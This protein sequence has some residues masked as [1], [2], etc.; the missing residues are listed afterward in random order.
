MIDE[1][2][3]WFNDN[4]M[5]IQWKFN[6][7]FQIFP[8]NFSPPEAKNILKLRI[9]NSSFMA[10]FSQRFQL[11]DSTFIHVNFTLNYSQYRRLP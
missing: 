7:S 5:E 11:V 10:L 9:P 3:E 1:I 6:K 4:S 8:K 2:G